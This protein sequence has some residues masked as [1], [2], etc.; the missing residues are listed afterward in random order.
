MSLDHWPWLIKRWCNL[1][2]NNRAF[3][4]APLQPGSRLS[5]HCA[6]GARAAA[7]VKS[8]AHHLIRSTST[9]LSVLCT[10]PYCRRLIM[11]SLLNLC[12]IHCFFCSLAEDD[13][14]SDQK[15]CSSA[16]QNTGCSTARGE[17]QKELQGFCS[18]RVS[19]SVVVRSGAKSSRISK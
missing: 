4:L 8:G 1:S 12:K 6:N 11:S 2:N 13:D 5:G 15:F 16:P 19:L 7:G 10:P 18:L 9:L 3:F 17:L 14:E